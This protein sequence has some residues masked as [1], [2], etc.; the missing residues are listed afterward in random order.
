MKVLL[1][2]LSIAFLSCSFP[3]EVTEPADS[4]PVT[5]SVR[6]WRLVYLGWD[7]NELEGAVDR[8]VRELARA[9]LPEDTFHCLILRESRIAS[10]EAHLIRNGERVATPVGN[11]EPLSLFDESSLLFL[12]RWYRENFPADREVVIVAA[13]GRGWRGIGSGP[14]GDTRMVDASTLP[15]L[16]GSEDAPSDIVVM[17]AAYGASAELLVGLADGVARMVASDG[18]RDA[19]GLDFSNFGELLADR[20]NRGEP[21]EIVA[22]L[23]DAF[24]ADSDAPVVLDREELRTLGSVVQSCADAGATMIRSREQQLSVQ[25]SLLDSALIHRLPG[26]AC[27][28]LETLADLMAVPVT[29]SSGRV[30]L[31]LVHMNEL[32]VP[33]G[34][35][36]GYRRNTEDSVLSPSFRSLPWAP[37]MARHDGFLYDLWYRRF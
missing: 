30:L 1:L 5:G 35:D 16:F 11:S 32:G 20:W 7:D 34:H 4:S 25:E 21:E 2:T 18:P 24:S 29:P 17:D 19:E 14:A 27:V 33:E 6:P 28:S 13:H 15:A 31:H 8:D 12:R 37:D 9:G 26:D 22:A 36:P 10:G 23:V 3:G